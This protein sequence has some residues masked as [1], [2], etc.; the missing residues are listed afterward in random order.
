MGALQET[1]QTTTIDIKKEIQN[2]PGK[3]PALK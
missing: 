1:E 3:I 2:S